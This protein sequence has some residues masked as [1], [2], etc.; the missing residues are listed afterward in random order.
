[1]V[2]RCVFTGPRG[3][4]SVQSVWGGL[5]Y[6]NVQSP[7][8]QLSGTTLIAVSAA[9]LTTSIFDVPLPESA[10]IEPDTSITASSCDGLAAADHRCM[11]VVCCCGVILIGAGCTGRG[12]MPGV[13]SAGSGAPDGSR[14]PAA[15][16]R[17]RADV[18]V[19]WRSNFAIAAVTSGSEPAGATRTIGKSSIGAG[20]L[21]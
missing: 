10:A 1:M 3:T 21:G 18:V 12:A 2:R 6:E 9:W 14:S 8:V 11:A 17:A 7:T 5:W 20:P 15:A 4:S 13:P 19:S 16:K